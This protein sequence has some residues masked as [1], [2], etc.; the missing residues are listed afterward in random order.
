METPRDNGDFRGIV[1]NFK[2]SE[3]LVFW[4]IGKVVRPIEF[5]PMPA[6][7]VSTQGGQEKTSAIVII[8][9]EPDP[10]EIMRVENSNPCFIVETETLEPGR[11]YQSSLTM[12]GD[13]PAGRMRD[14]AYTLARNPRNNT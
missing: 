12:K 6:F 13:G 4:L 14:L 2:A 1:V 11:R 10:F 7:F 5:D 8:H 9:H 3:S